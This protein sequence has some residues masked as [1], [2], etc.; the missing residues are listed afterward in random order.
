MSAARN[1]VFLGLFLFPVIITFYY[2]YAVGIDIF[3]SRL[4][5]SASGSFA[6]PA[7]LL[8]ATI[9]CLARRPW[10]LA[11]VS[12]AAALWMIVLTAALAALVAVPSTA[13]PMPIRIGMTLCVYVVGV[14]L[15][16]LVLQRHA[17]GSAA[18]TCLAL[19]TLALHALAH[20]LQFGS[21]SSLFDWGAA[22]V[23]VA[24]ALP[25]LVALRYADRHPN[26]P[27][28]RRPKQT[29]TFG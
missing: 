14:M 17:A 8:W 28:D 10:W 6:G 29:Y 18:L 3:F 22:P 20:R 15:P 2:V 27:R 24:S 13:W 9:V 4:V 26:R 16:V 23:W 19:L 7:I 11:C 12:L 5:H 25:L 1:Y 21:T